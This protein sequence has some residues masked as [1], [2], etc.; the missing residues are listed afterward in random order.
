M[1]N[2]RGCNI[3]NKNGWSVLAIDKENVETRIT[4]KMN[5]EQ[6]KN[7][8]FHQEEFE[9]I[10]QLEKVKLIVANYSLPF[11]QKDKFS[12]MWEKIENS[13]EENGYFV[14]NFF[15]E[16]DSWKETR[17]EITILSKREIIEMFSKFDIIKFQETEKDG[18]TGLGTSKHWHIYNIIAQKK[19]HEKVM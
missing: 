5:E 14:G 15:G 13:I 6:L 11:C 17:P 7:F 16:K 8:Q 18:K 9:N 10:N 4:K 2:W 19:K 12:Q 1:W 3:F